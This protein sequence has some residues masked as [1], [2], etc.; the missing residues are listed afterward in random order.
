M[1]LR[2]SWDDQHP[3]PV[4]LGRPRRVGRQPC[5]TRSACSAW[6]RRER[7]DALADDPGFM[8]FLGEVRDELQRYLDGDRW[9]QPRG[10]SAAAVGR[11]LLARVRHRRGAPA[12]L[13]RPRR[14]GRRPPQGGQRPRRAAGRRSA[15]STATATS[16]SRCRRDGWQQER[17]PDLD[18]HAMA[19]TP[20]DGITVRG[21]PGRRAA[22]GAGLAGR[23]RPGAALPARR[24]RRGERPRPARR[25]PTASTA[26]TP[27]TACARRSCSASAA[28][29]PSTALGH[30]RPG[31]PHQRGPRRLPRPRAHP[32]AR[33]GRRASPSPRPSRR[34]GRRASSPPTRRCRPASTASP[35]S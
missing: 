27:S 32:P 14:A 19:L 11:L 23:R 3:R 34:C 21:R 24:R 26:A 29:A 2:W 6:C 12:V 13:G 33:G 8:R 15:S 35:A 22:R 4:P 30:R 31:V 18:P 10:E 1:N 5:T 16:A 7:L 9:F 28:C 25:S 17:Y 20:C